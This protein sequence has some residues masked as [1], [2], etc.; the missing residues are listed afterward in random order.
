MA[1]RCSC[2]KYVFWPSVTSTKTAAVQTGLLVECYCKMG[3]CWTIATQSVCLLI[4]YHSI[5]HD[6]WCCAS[7]S[8]IPNF[9]VFHYQLCLLVWC[10]TIGQ[11][12]WCDASLSAMSSGV[13]SHHRLRLLAWSLII[14]HAHWCGASL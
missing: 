14:N 6:C 3:A 2:S 13:L 7:L 9:M 8:A 5:L 1:I 11:A 10:L 12:F 4:F